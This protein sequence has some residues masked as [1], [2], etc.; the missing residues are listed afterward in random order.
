MTGEEMERAIE[1]LLQG[2]ANFEVRLTAFDTRLDRLTE[3]VDQLTVKVDQLTGSVEQ[4]AGEVRE[5]RQQLQLHVET[6]SEFIKVVTSHIEA[7]SRFNDDF[8]A[9]QTRLAEGSLSLATT[10]QRFIEGRS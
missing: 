10:V 5:M 3:R 6:Q 9:T 2:Q 8:R 7:Q 4:L 1:F